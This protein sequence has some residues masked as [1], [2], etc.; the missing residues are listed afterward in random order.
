MDWIPKTFTS[1]NRPNKITIDPS[2]NHH[3]INALNSTQRA[4][5]DAGV[6]TLMSAS[7]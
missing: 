7:I 2:I 3:S 6:N 1:P 4:C 5:T